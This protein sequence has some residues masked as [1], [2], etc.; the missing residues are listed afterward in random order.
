MEKPIDRFKHFLS[1]ASVI[2]EPGQLVEVRRRQ[3]VVSDVQGQSIE[4]NGKQHVVTLSSLD[5]DALG[6]ELQVVWQIEPGAQVLEK[7]GMPRI[8]G[9]D[10][11]DKSVA[12]LDAVRWGAVTN[13]DRS[14][15]QAPFR[16]GITIEDY[17][18]DPLVRAID[19]ARVNLL[20]A[21][22]VGL[23]KT[24][25]AGLVVQELL[26]RHRARTV[27]IV[28]PASL[29]VKWQVE[30]WEKFGLEFRIVDTDYIKRLRRERGIHAN[31]WT[32]FPRLITSMDWM[33]SGEGLRLVKDCLPPTFTYPRKFDI[34]IIDEAHNV[35]PST[36]SKYAL[37]SQRTR[38]IRTIAPH[39]EHRLFLSATPHNGYQESFTSLLELLDDQRFARSVMPD[40]KQLQRVMVRRLK[41]DLVDADGKPLYAK[42]RLMP[43]EIDYS[44]EEREIHELLRQF[45]AARAK[46]VK[47]SSFDF[48]SD[49]V[50][51]LLKK[52]LFSSP[53]AFAGTLAKHRESLERPRSKQKTGVMDD[54]ILKKAIL[55]AE[56]DF[57]ND[58]LYEAAQYEAVEAAGELSVPLDQEQR[59]MLDKLTAWAEKTKNRIDAKATA[60]V[61]WLKAHLKTDGQWNGKR[62]ILFTEFRATH[63]WM[64]QILTTHGFGGEHMMLMHGGVDQKDREKIKAAFQAH[65]DISPV[66]ILLATDAASEGIDL[67]NYCNYMIHIEIPWNPN[68]ME[69]RNGRI[70]RHGQKESEVFIWHPV[71]KGF[72]WN[73][74][75]HSK[76]V[77]Q[78]EGDHEYLMRAVLKI[79]TIREDLGS[80][81][82]VIAQQIEEAMLGKRTVLDTADAE[83][84]A[85]KARKYVSAERRLKEKIDKLHERLMEAKTDFHLSSEH[86]YRAVSIA[87]ELA[88]KPPLKPVALP[89]ASDG[90]VFEVPIFPGSWGRAMAGLEHPHTGE[91]RPITFDH[92]VAKGRD[93]VVLAHLNHRL[94]QMCLRL[95][96]EE[97]WKLDD[98]KKLHRVSV[99]VVTDKVLEMPAVLVWS[100]LVIT[101]GDHHRLHEEITIS[102]GELKHTGFS[103]IPQQGRLQD[104]L[105]KAVTFEPKGGLLDILSER[106]EKQESSIRATMEARS[107]DRLRFLE[108]TLGRRKDGEI[109]DLTSALDELEKTIRNEL[110]D[111]ALPKQMVLPGFEPDERNQ[112]R[113]DIEAL[114]IRLARIPEERELENT[115]IK[116]RYAGLTDRTFPVAVVFIVPESQMG[117]VTK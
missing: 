77:G 84:K 108:T 92:E 88:E 54:K 8:T 112:I 38:L 95:L 21:D 16:S 96:R 94:V 106:F 104:L 82:P 100:R 56:E 101:G 19:M 83:R 102:G 43:L 73:K 3:W 103:R 13:A 26:V 23:G 89:G 109:A 114:R 67:Q 12:F 59:Q 68:V 71:G 69:Q 32:S 10:S 61:D 66:R 52:R 33:K 2:P 80:V 4:A 97:L 81:G 111:D 75:I 87:L 42:R 51:K 58:Q 15:L 49:F 30:M 14:F 50:H 98:V 25:E 57:A 48:G 17:Q 74:S 7:A 115:A 1:V 6:E 60:I 22:D 46:S 99:K 5:E 55:K 62:V 110:K 24:I 116:K 39:F 53:M 117:E 36:A 65:P 85:A 79:D 72:E 86:I 27:F 28:C 78:I 35:A 34:L 44:A 76:K 20:I 41:T 45:T 70:D 40:E 37:E 11:E 29:Q 47:G 93:D 31:P 91:R 9:I 113:K 63:V 90:S 107:K 18:L 64:E 105:D